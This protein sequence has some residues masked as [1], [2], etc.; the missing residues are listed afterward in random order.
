[1]PTSPN[2]SFTNS[3][4]A[5]LPRIPLAKKPAN[6]TSGVRT[7]PDAVGTGF[8]YNERPSAPEG[9]AA[10]EEHLTMSLRENRTAKLRLVENETPPPASVPGPARDD[11]E[12]LAAMRA[13]EEGAASSFHDRCRT[14]V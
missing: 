4:K 11:I 12:L 9:S 6:R 10:A 13:N 7:R 8:G 5:M 14:Q 1:M 3:V 2:S